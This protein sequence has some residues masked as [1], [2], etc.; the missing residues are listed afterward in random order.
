MAGPWKVVLLASVVA[1]VLNTVVSLL[2]PQLG[3]DGS[4]SGCIALCPDNALAITSQP[5]LAVDLVELVRFAVI[6]IDLATGGLLVW[7]MVAGTP[8]QRRALVIG[9]P[10]ALVFLLLHITYQVLKLA[11]PDG[12]AVHSVIQWGVAGARSLIWYGFLFALIAAQLFAGRVLHSLVRQSLRRPSRNE[13]EAMMRE[14]LGDPGLRLAIWE[15]T[16]E[17][18]T[19]TDTDTDTDTDTEGITAPTPEPGREL[20]IVERG[21]GTPAVAIDHDAQLDDDPELLRAVGAVALLAAENAASNDAQAEL[22]RSHA[23]I[24]AAGDSERMKLERNLHDGAQQRLVAVR[25]R[26]ALAGERVAEQVTIRHELDGIGE[27]VEEAIEELREVAHG[28][29]PPVLSERG[30][31]AALMEIRRHV[32]APIDVRAANIDQ[33]P[34]ELESAVYYCCLEAIQNATK[35]GGPTVQITVRLR[36][37][38]DADEL[39]FEVADDGPGFDLS[40]A[41]TG[42]GLQNMRDRVGALSGHISIVTTPGHGTTVSGSIPLHPDQGHGYAPALAHSPDDRD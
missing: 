42:A 16:T 14:P 28:L 32:T 21:D 39:S 7:R 11:D 23:R 8:P 40:G 30:L 18:W 33:H 20:A 29:Y 36:E 26:L 2:V 41:H 24:V 17:T 22:R 10:I 12:A 6:V 19:G 25:I 38:R 15:P 34:A 5:S 4:I 3:P 9:A 35:R 37:G 1:F 13:L 31:R 27:D